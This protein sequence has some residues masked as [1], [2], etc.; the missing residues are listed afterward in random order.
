[1]VPDHAWAH[2]L[3]GF[4]QIHTNRAAQ[5]IAEC[6][7]ALALD[8]NL[9]IAH[10]VIGLA[11]IFIGRFEE[12]ETRVQE[13]ICLSP[14]DKDLYAWLPVAGIAKLYLG[15]DDEEV[16]CFRRSIEI[17]RNHPGAQYYLAGALALLGRLE[18]ARGA[19]R[20]AMTLHLDFTISRLCGGASE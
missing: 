4:V 19:V 20:A 11:K 5:G 1:M 14:R 7:R 9:A 12:T 6:E 3:M 17:N 16:T 10:T 15:G 8:P 18:E 2:V 13:A